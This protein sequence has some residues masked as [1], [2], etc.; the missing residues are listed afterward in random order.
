MR[1]I[2][3]P[4][5]PLTELKCYA[6][7]LLRMAVQQNAIVSIYA[8]PGEERCEAFVDVRLG[9]KKRHRWEGSTWYKT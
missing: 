4:D 2:G 3:D 8:M 6:N 1:Q 7:E 9:E 5:A